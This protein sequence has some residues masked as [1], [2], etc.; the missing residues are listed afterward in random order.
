MA[1][2]LAIHIYHLAFLQIVST[3]G[4][5]IVY[6][7]YTRRGRV[8]ERTARRSPAVIASQLEHVSA[9]DSFPTIAFV[10]DTPRYIE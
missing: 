1:L 7:A 6:H 2:R 10:T 3:S 9:L 8:V 5:N 4:S